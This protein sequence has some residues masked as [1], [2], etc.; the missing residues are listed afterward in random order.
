MNRFEGPAAHLL[1]IWSGPPE[2]RSIGR[3]LSDDELQS[4]GFHGSHMQLRADRDAWGA[5]VTEKSYHSDKEYLTI[6]EVIANI[7]DFEMARRPKTNWFGGI[8]DHH[9]FFEGMIPNADGA[10]FNI[11]WGS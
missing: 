7:I 8:D 4:P 10:S 1:H 3:E 6:Q 2:W 5:E 9:V 11:C